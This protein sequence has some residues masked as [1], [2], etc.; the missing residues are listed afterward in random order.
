M[1]AVVAARAVNAAVLLRETV[2]CL[3]L[4]VGAAV[5]IC[6]VTARLIQPGVRIFLDLLHTSMA[7][8]AIHLVFIGHD[9]AQAL[10]LRARVALVASIL[11]GQDMLV[12]FIMNSLRKIGDALHAKSG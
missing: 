11:A 9:A 10:R 5:A 6:I 1:G 7:V 4:L 3:I 12:V 2:Q 8:Q